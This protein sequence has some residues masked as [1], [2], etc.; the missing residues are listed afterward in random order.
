MICIWHV[1]LFI[2]RPV[3]YY[4]RQSE[5]SA[6]YTTARWS[7]FSAR[8]ISTGLVKVDLCYAI[9]WAKWTGEKLLL[10]SYWHLTGCVKCFWIRY[11]SFFFCRNH[12]VNFNLYSVP[13]PRL[14]WNWSFLCSGLSLV[15]L[16]RFR[17][18]PCIYIMRFRLLPSSSFCPV[19]QYRH[20]WLSQERNKLVLF[21]D[22]VWPLFL[23]LSLRFERYDKYGEEVSRTDGVIVSC[24]QSVQ[25][26]VI[27]LLSITTAY[28]KVKS[29]PDIFQEL[30]FFVNV[31]RQTSTCIVLETNTS[32]VV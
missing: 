17:F 3:L 24:R 14:A 30:K 19:L 11:P 10:M 32:L 13:L 20:E 15:V 7:A 9:Y 5:S 27:V 31:A 29:K 16:A 25:F 28:V 8:G 23:F 1:R 12:V 26:R 22:F 2:Y 18:W 21:D 4:P 6:K